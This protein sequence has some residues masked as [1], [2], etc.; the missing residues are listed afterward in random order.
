MRRGTTPTL[1]FTLPFDAGSITALSIAFAQ[2]GRVVLEKE[3]KDCTID[4]QAI[5]LELTEEDTLTFDIGSDWVEIQLRVGIGSR[6]LASNII[7]T[8]VSR[9]LRDGLLVGGDGT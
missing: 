4:G 9:I 1:K 8:V 5:T 6:R 2:G 3:L 7:R